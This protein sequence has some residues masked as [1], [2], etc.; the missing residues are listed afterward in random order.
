MS[1]KSP[2]GYASK[3]LVD[4]EGGGRGR[5]RPAR[6]RAKEQIMNDLLNEGRI[7][8]EQYGPPSADKWRL[9]VVSRTIP[10]VS[11]EEN[12]EDCE[13]GLISVLCP[14]LTYLC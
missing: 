6:I 4:D 11:G 10:D 5:D 2:K 1:P 12:M 7:V 13:E 14:L 8:S 3:A 9:K